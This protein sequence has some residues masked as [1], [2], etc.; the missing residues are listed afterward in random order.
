MLMANIVPTT[1]SHHGA[2]GGMDS[3]SSQAVSN[4]LLSPRN[5]LMGRLRSLSMTA[6]VASAVTL[7]SASDTRMAGP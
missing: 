1:T 5:G 7:A 6:S 2:S 4:A 3:A